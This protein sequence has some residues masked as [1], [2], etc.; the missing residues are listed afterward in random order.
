MTRN[1]ADFEGGA[2]KFDHPMYEGGD[3]P[4]Y[5]WMHQGE[6]DKAQSTG[7]FKQGINAARV[8]Q[9]GYSEPTHVLVKFAAQP[10]GVWSNKYQPGRENKEPFYQARQPISFE[11]G[12]IVDK[13]RKA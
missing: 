12:E 7:F 4:M 10:K 6:Y 8:P 13:G 5:R 9:N 3:Q 11:H 1:N 2:G